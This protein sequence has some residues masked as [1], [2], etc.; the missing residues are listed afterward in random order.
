[1]SETN[2]PPV[3]RWTPHKVHCIVS[4]AVI[5][6][7]TRRVR[8]EFLKRFGSTLIDSPLHC[9]VLYVAKGFAVKGGEV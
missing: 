5:L 8:E 2:Q 7:G 6:L 3:E 9:W 1:M 4:R